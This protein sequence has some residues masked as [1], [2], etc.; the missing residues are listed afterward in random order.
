[1]KE[2]KDLIVELVVLLYAAYVSALLDEVQRC[3]AD[4]LLCPFNTVN[5]EVILASGDEHNGK[6]VVLYGAQI[7]LQLKL[8]PEELA[9]PHPEGN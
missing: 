2:R 5:K 4:L 3:F 9:E 7:L 8:C 6:F 1:M